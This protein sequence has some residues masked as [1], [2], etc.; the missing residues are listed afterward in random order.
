VAVMTADVSS[1][2][3][4]NPH[5]LEQIA[6]NLWVLRY[7]L[8]VLGAQMGR[9]TTLIRLRNGDLII[10]ST[11]PFT[12]ADVAVITALGRPAFLVEAT[13]FH[14]TFAKAGCAAF[15]GVPYFAPPGFRGA[16]VHRSLK[17]VA[18]E[19]SGE[20]E[21][22]ELEGMP[23][24]REHVFFHPPSR[25]LIVADLLFN[26]GAQSTAWTRWFF[27]WLG[28]IEQF[29]GMSRLFRASIKD[30]AVFAACANQMM[31]WDF[32]RCIVAHGDVIESNARATL[33]NALTTHG[34]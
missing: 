19:W 20:L 1:S 7:P 29:P 17:E 12:P 23:R 4:E 18:G 33:A 28:G 5:R 13:L 21:V 11:G 34:F 31:L 3:V 22:L 25:T 16:D 27:R 9:T 26:F 10:H 2:T 32:D 24:V 6:N 15:P 8:Q 14:D 30:R